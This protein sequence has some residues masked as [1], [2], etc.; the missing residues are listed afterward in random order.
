MSWFGKTFPTE[1]GSTDVWGA[2]LNALFGTAVDTDTRCQV[3]IPMV[4]R[5]GTYTIILNSR[6][7]FTIEDASV[8]TDAGTATVAVLINSSPV[9]GLGAIS[10]SSTQA[11]AAAT[12]DK[13]VAAG[14]D[15]KITL[16]SVSGATRVT[17]NLWINRTG[18][19][20]A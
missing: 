2:L 19:G 5:N 4:A 7:P 15:V 12:T 18:E 13:T 14:D 17:V 16:S 9:G 10:A 6:F 3:A 8:I 11:D 1:F 20:T